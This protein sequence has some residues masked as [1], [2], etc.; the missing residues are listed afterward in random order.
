MKQTGPKYIYIYIFISPQESHNSS[1][2]S[3]INHPNQIRTQLTAITSHPNVTTS[4]ERNRSNQYHRKAIR[5]C[6]EK[7]QAS[8]REPRR[9]WRCEEAAETPR[10]SSSQQES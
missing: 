3:L 2:T 4:T 5:S 7:L 6:G 1:A 10:S 8:K 9:R